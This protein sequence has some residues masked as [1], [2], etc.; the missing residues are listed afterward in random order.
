MTAT[1]YPKHRPG[2]RARAPWALPGLGTGFPGGFSWHR[3]SLLLIGL[4]SGF[5]ISSNIDVDVLRLRGIHETRRAARDRAHVSCNPI[6]NRCA[7]NWRFFE[8][9]FD[10][11]GPSRNLMYT[12]QL[13]YS[14]V[15][16][17]R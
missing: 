7:G 15:Y 2:E 9:K 6:S 10:S 13:K 12:A 17:L 3:L 14:H 5:L 16:I 8:E 1:L 4:R 11:S